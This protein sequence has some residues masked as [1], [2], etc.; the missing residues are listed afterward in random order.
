MVPRWVRGTESAEIVD[1]PQHPIAMLGLG[2]SVATPP[3]GLEA[4]VIVVGSYDELAAARGRG[5]G[6]DRAL[7]RALHELRR[8]EPVSDRRRLG[9]GAARRGGGAGA[10]D[11]PGWPAHAAHRRHDLRRGRR[12]IPAAAMSAEDAERMQRLADRGRRVRVRLRDAGAVRGRRRVGQRDR[13][14][15]GPR[16]AGRDRAGRRALR[17]VG[18]R[19]R[20]VG[21]WRGVRG[22]VGSRAADEEAGH[23]PAPHGARRA[24]HERRERP[25]RRARP[26]ATPTW[27]RRRSTCWRSSRTPGCSRRR[28]SASPARRGRAADDARD[29]D[30]AGAA[31][32]AGRSGRAAAA[33]TS[34]RSRRPAACR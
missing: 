21:R 6:Q 8:D 17:L 30:A 23:P 11:R 20:R 32:S 18:C 4:D 34:A 14:D 1:P 29:R 12:A 3:G 13:R 19:H 22:D 2:G 15:P 31:R 16:E 27:R 7:Q 9:R 26:I 24:V 10:R 5:E 28:G 25:A 33:P